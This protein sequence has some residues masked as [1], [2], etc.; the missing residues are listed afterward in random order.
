MTG[1]VY[2]PCLQDWIDGLDEAALA[3]VYRDMS[4]PGA[5]R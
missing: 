3:V 4:L 5:A 2:S 1:P